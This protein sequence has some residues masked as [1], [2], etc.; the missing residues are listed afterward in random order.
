MSGILIYNIHRFVMYISL[1]EHISS[2]LL[3]VRKRNF[4]ARPVI[5]HG[6]ISKP[7]SNIHQQRSGCSESG[8]FAY[9]ITT[10]KYTH[11]YTYIYHF[12]NRTCLILLL[13]MRR[14]N[15]RQWCTCAPRTGSI[16]AQLCFRLS[17]CMCWRRRRC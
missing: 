17:R 11:L 3:N 6:R 8:I 1:F 2:R 13:S 7:N 14:C 4:Y 12:S 10:F 15:R 5:S 9:Y 16:W